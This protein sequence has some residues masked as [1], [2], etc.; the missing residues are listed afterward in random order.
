[1]TALAVAGT[2]TVH[3]GT[4]GAAPRIVAAVTSQGTD[5]IEMA[6]DVPNAG[7]DRLRRA[8]EHQVDLVEATGRDARAKA[9]PQGFPM[10]VRTGASAGSHDS[11]GD[12]VTIAVADPGDDRPILLHAYMNVYHLRM[13]PGG[14]RN[15][16][17]REVVP[18]A[19]LTDS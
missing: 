2:M 8:A 7:I 9:F 19:N 17:T 14:N 12:S 18:A 10:V 3:G 6:R 16:D 15:P 11:G 1:M 13:L 5:R 4:V